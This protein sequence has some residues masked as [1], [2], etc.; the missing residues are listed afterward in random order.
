MVSLKSYF[1]SLQAWL[2]LVEPSVLLFSLIELNGHLCI[3]PNWVCFAPVLKVNLCSQLPWESWEIRLGA[4]LSLLSVFTLWLNM[5]NMREVVSTAV[6][7]LPLQPCGLKSCRGAQLKW[8]RMGGDFLT[9]TGKGEEFAFSSKKALGIAVRRFTS[10]GNLEEQAGVCGGWGWGE[11]F[12]PAEWHRVGVETGQYHCS[13]IYQ[14][15]GYL[16]SAWKHVVVT[17]CFFTAR[18][19]ITLGAE[20]TPERGTFTSGITSPFL[21][22]THFLLSLT[23]LPLCSCSA[24]QLLIAVLC[25]HL[26][27]WSLSTANLNWPSAPVVSC[28]NLF[29][30]CCWSRN[31]LP[32]VILF[33]VYTLFSAFLDLFFSYW[34]E[35]LCIGLCL[36]IQIMLILPCF[37]YFTSYTP[38]KWNL[39][40]LIESSRLF[41]TPSTT[42]VTL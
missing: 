3:F 20:T 33:T 8:W 4:V 17:H 19:N 25:C 11:G 21:L 39:K 23:T 28:S 31:L 12:E 34:A 42:T 18:V 35:F 10:L 6:L 27:L 13:S 7:L 26:S 2:S 5:S 36:Q 14:L 38:S 40:W 16:G 24:A 37:C 32:W 30:F 9:P 1:E 22:S 41:A 29:S 15:P